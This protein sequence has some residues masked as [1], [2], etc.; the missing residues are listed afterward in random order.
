MWITATVPYLVMLVLLIR[1]L[2]LEGSSIGIEFYLSIDDWS[3]LT[4]MKVIENIL[5]LKLSFFLQL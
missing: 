5:F 1:G 2:T 4:D 3:S